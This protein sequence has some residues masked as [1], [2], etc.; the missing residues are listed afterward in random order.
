MSKFFVI[1]ALVVLPLLGQEEALKQRVQ[2]RSQQVVELLSAGVL[3]EGVDGLLKPVG[4]IEPAQSQLM[5]EENQD[6]EAIFQ[7]I[8]GKS[9]VPVEEVRQMYAKRAR[10]KYPAAAVSAGAGPCKL[11]PAKA[12]D[13]A[14]LLQYLKQGMMYA[15]QKKFEQA[16]AEFQPALN[17]DRNFLGLNQNVGSAQLALKK[18]AEAEAAFQAEVKLTECLAGMNEGQLANFGYFF[19]VAE[20]DA[21]ARKRAQAEKLKAELPKAR[22]N[23]HYNLACV[24]SLQ[25]QKD[26]ALAALRA[27]VDAGFADKRVLNGDSDLAFV[28]QAPE[29]RE[30]AA[31]LK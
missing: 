1:A 7:L 22:A 5:R 24:Y 28:R 2:A 31:R 4:Q 8:A 21:A 19:E 25:K 3:M 30:I 10:A 13:V 17:I 16:L 27:A 18:Y 26:P 9:N 11:V 6:R 14:R 12:P 15:S 29:F 20:K 23:A